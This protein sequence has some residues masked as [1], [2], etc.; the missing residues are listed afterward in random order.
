MSIVAS[1]AACALIGAWTTTLIY[2]DALIALSCALGWFLL[3]LAIVDALAFR[4]P[5]VLT[6]PLIAGGLAASQWLP[7]HDLIGHVIACLL[8]VAIFY[9]I[10][11]AY[12][13]ARGQDGLGMGDAKLA[14]AAGAWLGWQAMPYVVLLACAVGFLW[15]GIAMIRR[16]KAALAERIPFGVALCFAIWMIWLYGPP[17]VSGLLL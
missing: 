8:G 14:G 2:D 5:D 7:G 16:G 15:V 17:D 9:G 4:L 3:V 1:V 13:R 6:L 12:R 11:V 10:A